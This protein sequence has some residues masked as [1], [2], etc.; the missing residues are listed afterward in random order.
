MADAMDNPP[1]EGCY[2]FNTRRGT[3]CD[4]LGRTWHP[5][6][7]NYDPGP[8]PPPKPPGE[9]KEHKQKVLRMGGD[10]E[11]PRVSEVSRQP[12][13]PQHAREHHRYQKPGEGSNHKPHWPSEGAPGSSSGLQRHTEMSGGQ[14]PGYGGP[15]PIRQPRGGGRGRG[16]GR[17]IAAF[18]KCVRGLFRMSRHL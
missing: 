16:D 17:R 4:P 13:Q 3:L 5:N 11:M 12:K 1:A 8:P 10:N 14:G 9:K 2:S 7:P 18:K 6:N 15:G